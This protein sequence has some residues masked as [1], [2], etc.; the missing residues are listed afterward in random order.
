MQKFKDAAALLPIGICREM[1]E[2]P[3][4]VT[5]KCEEIRL[6][7]GYPISLAYDGKEHDI[8]EGH[9]ICND[10]IEAVIEKASGASVHSVESNIANGFLYVD[11]G[12][13]LGLCGTAVRKEN[14]ALGLRDFSSIAIRIPHEVRNCGTDILNALISDGP[15]D[16]LIISPPGAGKTTC[17][18][19]YVRIIS[20]S[21]SRVSLVDERGEVAGV[22]NGIAQFDVGRHTDIMQNLPKREAS[23]MMLRAMN[24]QLLAMDEISSPEDVKAIEEVSGCGVK[25]LA[26]AH[27]KDVAD[28]SKRPVYRELLRKQIFKYAIVIENIDAKR[29]YRA[30][31]LCP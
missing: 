19:E 4:N 14:G 30:E 1:L 5:N 11:G 10:D 2:L 24:P 15:S 21:G 28:L 12:I 9:K 25:I 7:T 31:E 17:I 18:R 27:A 29:R 6:R 13:R 8:I 23:I 16:I 26:T 20:N 3:E 22:T